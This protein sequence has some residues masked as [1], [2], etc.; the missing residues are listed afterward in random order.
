MA[1]L[2]ACPDDAL[3]NIFL[4]AASADDIKA[5]AVALGPAGEGVFRAALP[6]L[7]H[8]VSGSIAATC[9]TTLHEKWGIVEGASQKP[10]KG[11]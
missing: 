5:L 3:R 4:L 10:S 6:A 9:S 11:F 1:S 7:F 8:R 2:Q